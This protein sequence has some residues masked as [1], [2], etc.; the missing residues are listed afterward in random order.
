MGFILVSCK[1]VLM[2]RLLAGFFLEKTV[3]T[4]PFYE[5]YSLWDA[6]TINSHEA[7]YYEQ[8]HSNEIVC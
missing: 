6:S 7:S 4:W 8:H 3:P 1:A 5:F 2:A